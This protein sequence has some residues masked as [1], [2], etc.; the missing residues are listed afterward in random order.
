MN[1][2]ANQ[3]RR[4]RREVLQKLGAG[5]G[6]LAL[7]TLLH[8]DAVASKGIHDLSQRSPG[9]KP[10]AIS[11]IQLFMHG[12]PSQVDLLDPKP[13]LNLCALLLGQ[14][15]NQHRQHLTQRPPIKAAML[16]KRQSAFWDKLSYCQ[17]PIQFICF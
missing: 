16:K 12:G 7:S 17:K 9:V 8:E 15:R 13:M 11:V 14:N 10:R 3:T 1:Q 6:G 5:F 2:T 4:S